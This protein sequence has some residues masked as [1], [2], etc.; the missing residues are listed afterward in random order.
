MN[1]PTVL[2]PA[3][4]PAESRN[5]SEKTDDV[6]KK[7]AGPADSENFS[8]LLYMLSLT[9]NNVSVPGV[10]GPTSFPSKLKQAAELNKDILTSGPVPL[11]RQINAGDEDR[12]GQGAETESKDDNIS[13]SGAKASM[14]LNGDS[15]AYKGLLDLN[16]FQDDFNKHLEQMPETTVDTMPEIIPNLVT[17]VASV[18]SNEVTLQPIH[19]NGPDLVSHLSDKIIDLYH[20]GGNSA[21]ISLQPEELGHLHIDLSVIKDS[22]NAIITVEDKS[23]KGIIDANIDTLVEQLRRS[24]L[25]VDQVTVNIA[26]SNFD[27]NI[28]GGWSGR[29]SR[30]MFNDDIFVVSHVND[31]NVLSHMDETL[32]YAGSAVG[33]SI[34]V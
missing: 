2:P 3:E 24:G 33:L 28:S 19:T 5:A 20:I 13:F 16:S 34:F 32:L 30:N 7:P 29:N 31:E 23:V 9:G 17:D 26:P 6:K 10:E 12:L 18:N 4:K 11:F 1:M 8:E 15:D 21:K 25:N 14:S 22:I 27:G